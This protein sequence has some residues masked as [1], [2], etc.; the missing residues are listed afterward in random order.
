MAVLP[1]GIDPATVRSDVIATARDRYGNAA[2]NRA[3]ASS[4]YLIVK[5][6]AGM[7]P[8]P[9][10]GAGADWRPPTP[11][12]L[13]IRDGE[14]WQ[15]A[16]ADGW[17]PGD[18]AAAAEIDR[19]LSDDRFWAEPTFVQACPDFGSSNAVLKLPRKHEAVRIAQCS[20]AAANLV[21]AALRT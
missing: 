16:T 19:I 5:R 14:T 8:P 15:V 11:A 18:V 13:L 1:A 21:E 4:A 2:M 6:F 10:P 3:L 12:A 20:S 9:P 7:A 17:R